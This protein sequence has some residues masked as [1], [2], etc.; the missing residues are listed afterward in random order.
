MTSAARARTVQPVGT[1]VAHS[2]LL[3]KPLKGKIYLVGTPASSRLKFKFPPP[4]R[5]TLTGVV[6]LGKD[7]VTIPE[8]SGVPLTQLTVSFP[9]GPRSLLAGG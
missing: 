8:V 7:S 5:L 4:A 1:A 2:P 3:P 9:G 6:S